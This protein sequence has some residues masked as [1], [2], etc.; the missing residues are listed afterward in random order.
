MRGTAFQEIEL[1][2]T[3]GIPVSI[4]DNDASDISLSASDY[5]LLNEKEYRVST[6]FILIIANVTFSYQQ[7]YICQRNR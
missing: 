6:M 4:I 5:Y 7:L 2:A 3:A 1:T